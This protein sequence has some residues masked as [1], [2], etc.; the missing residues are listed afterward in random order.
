MIL[1]CCYILAFV[2]VLLSIDR[3]LIIFFETCAI[4]LNKP[5]VLYSVFYPLES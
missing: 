2:Q 1:F 3:V 4:F 5:E